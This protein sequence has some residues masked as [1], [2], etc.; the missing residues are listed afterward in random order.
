MLLGRL[1]LNCPRLLTYCII[2]FWQRHCVIH[3]ATM[4]FS[5]STVNTRGKE[6]ESEGRERGDG[7]VSPKSAKVSYTM[8]TCT[9]ITLQTYAAL[10][11]SDCM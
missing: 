3:A 7:I 9:V 2:V 10:G 5:K 1:S 6:R 8:I 4:H 11:R